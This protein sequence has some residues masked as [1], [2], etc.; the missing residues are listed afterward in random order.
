MRAALLALA[1]ALAVVPACLDQT[2]TTVLIWGITV[3]VT[4][5]NGNPVD[6]TVTLRD[7]AYVEV[8]EPQERLGTLY[9][10]AGERPGVYDVT[11]MAGGHRDV[12][13]ENVRVEDGGCHVET[14][15]LTV[16]LEP[17]P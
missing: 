17:L 11:V 4:D 12:A 6:A 8:I 14:E 16:M 3:D 10:G 5:T 15:K 1:L 7:G 2:C 9:T 13:I